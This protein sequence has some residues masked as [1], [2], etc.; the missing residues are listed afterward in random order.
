MEGAALTAIQHLTSIHARRSRLSPL[1]AVALVIGC[2]PQPGGAVVPD[3]TARVQPPA[4][5]SASEPV[6][7]AAAATAPLATEAPASAIPQPTAALPSTSAYRIE[8]PRLGVN[9]PVA[10]GDVPRDIDQ[11]R[12]PEDYAFHLPGT[13]MFGAGNTYIYAHARPGM[14]LSLWNARLG[15]LVMA[16]T[17]SGTRE[18]VVAEI[19]PRVPPTQVSWAGPSADTRLT[20]QTS[21]GPNSDDPRFV[22]IARP[23]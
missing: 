21:T 10:E 14:F 16:R 19:H 5:S 22:V 11:E 20:L 6:P 3:A 12:T 4:P 2:S 23:R 13:S 15:D 7:T 9:L 18:Y 1:L 8:I 17:P